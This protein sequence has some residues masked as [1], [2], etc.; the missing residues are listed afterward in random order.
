MSLWKEYIAEREGMETIEHENGFI[1]FSINAKNKVCFI[2]D[3]FIRAE[4]RNRGYGQLLF[5]ELCDVAL[6]AGAKELIAQVDTRAKNASHSLGVILS[7]GFEVLGAE[8]GV[9][10]LAREVEYGRTC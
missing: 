4:E 10:T 5:D 6:K 2:R 7:R 8:H 9:I 3:M 1:T